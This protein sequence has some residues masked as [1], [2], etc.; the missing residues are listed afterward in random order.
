MGVIGVFPVDLVR[1]AASSLGAGGPAAPDR[2]GLD[3]A[4][5]TPHA[6]GSDHRIRAAAG[7]RGRRACAADGSGEELLRKLSIHAGSVLPHQHLLH[8]V[9]G[10]TKPGT[11]G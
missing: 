11:P 2:A 1:A 4:L 7:E 9:W 8:R 10:Q 6:G 5:G 3:S